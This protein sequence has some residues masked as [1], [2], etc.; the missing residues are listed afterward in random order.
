[1]KLTV[2]DR[3]ELYQPCKENGLTLGVITEIREMYG[4]PAYL[5]KFVDGLEVWCRRGE[6]KA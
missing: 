1:M 5:I 6:F 3:V 4:H 2:G